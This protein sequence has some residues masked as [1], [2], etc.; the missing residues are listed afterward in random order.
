MCGPL[1]APPAHLAAP[2]PRTADT[3][4]QLLRHELAFLAGWLSSGRPDADLR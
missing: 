1:M 4:S 3:F 2:D